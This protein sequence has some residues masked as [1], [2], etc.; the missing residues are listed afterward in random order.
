GFSEL[1]RI[2]A[3]ESSGIVY[4]AIKPSKLLFHFAKQPLDFVHFFEIGL[5]QRRRSALFG[6]R[7]RF[8][9]G[10]AVMDGH[11]IARLIQSQRDGAADAFG[12]ARYQDCACVAHYTTGSPWTSISSGSTPSRAGSGNRPVQLAHSQKKAVLEL[13]KPDATPMVRG[14]Q[15]WDATPA[16]AIESIIV[17]QDI[18]SMVANTRPRNSSETCRRS[19]DMLST[20][21]TAMAEREIARNSSAIWNA[22]I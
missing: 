1:Q 18:V 10:A 20:E 7:P 9:L 4:Q 6:R 15:L 14:L 3:A 11:A 17:D 8:L 12:R 21:L 19:C 16:P 2:A 5:E 13:S 22:R